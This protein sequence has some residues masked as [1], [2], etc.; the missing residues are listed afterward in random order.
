MY[1]KAG[2]FF[3]RRHGVRPWIWVD[4]DTIEGYGGEESFRNNIP[5]DVLLSNWYYSIIKN[6]DD[7]CTTN[8]HAALY[9]KIGQW[10]FEQVPTSSTWSWYLSS[11]Q[12]MRFCLNHVAAE[13]LRGFMTAP[14]LHCVPN[15]YYGLLNDAFVFGNAKK[16]IYGEG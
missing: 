2:R 3:C 13:S 9:Q 11:K 1:R 14:W 4:P 15:Q 16:D 5:K 6:S 8:K 12:T 7:V 10:G